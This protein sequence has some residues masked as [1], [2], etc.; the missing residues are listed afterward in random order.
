MKP[1][2]PALRAAK[3]ESSA[4]R[5]ELGLTLA[6]LRRRLS[7]KAMAL[8]A[9]HDIAVKGKA[10]AR[11]G[12]YVAKKHPLVLTGIAAAIGLVLARGRITRHFDRS[13]AMQPPR[14]P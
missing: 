13:R 8:D 3:A 12:V 9:A 14:A 2:A 10:I 5:M 7:P 11:D 1:D 6:A 4:A